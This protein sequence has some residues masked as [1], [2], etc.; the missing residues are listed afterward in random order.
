MTTERLA[1]LVLRAGAAF[2]FLYP[3][4]AAFYTPDSWIGYFPAFTRGVVPDQVLLHGFGIVEVIIGLWILS[5]KK[6]FIPSIL[7]TLMLLAIVFFNWGGFEVVF[8]DL[9]IAA[10]TLGLAI[11]QIKRNPLIQK[12]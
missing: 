10:L 8:R 4:V 3:P 2:A 11:M 1:Y 6:I 9:S 12:V 7:A 5:G